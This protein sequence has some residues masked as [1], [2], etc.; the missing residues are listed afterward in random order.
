M[1]TSWLSVEKRQRTN[2][3]TLP[4]GIAFGFIGR[5]PSRERERGPGDVARRAGTTAQQ[6]RRDA[7]PV[8]P[9]LERRAALLRNQTDN[10]RHP[11]ARDLQRM[12]AGSTGTEP[13]SKIWTGLSR[14]RTVQ[15]CHCEIRLCLGFFSIT[16]FQNDAK[17]DWILDPTGFLISRISFAKS[18][19]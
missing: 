19:V 15:R 12:A 18:F 6:H 3:M 17:I 5:W 14:R 10:D 11:A 4:G 7:S 2:K 8:E 1:T 9:P 13:R 16:F